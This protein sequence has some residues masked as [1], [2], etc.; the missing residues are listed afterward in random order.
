MKTL[1]HV[2]ENRIIIW[3]TIIGTLAALYNL[4]TGNRIGY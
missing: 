2:I 3:I 1:R 4:C